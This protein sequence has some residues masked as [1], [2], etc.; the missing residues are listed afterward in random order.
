MSQHHIPTSANNIPLYKWFN[1]NA[2]DAWQ[3]TPHAGWISAMFKSQIT[4]VTSVCLSSSKIVNRGT[5]ESH[6]WSS[7]PLFKYCIYVWWCFHSPLFIVIYSGFPTYVLMFFSICW[8]YPVLTPLPLSPWLAVSTS[9]AQVKP[10]Q[11]LE[12]FELWTLYSM[13]WFY[14]NIQTGNHGFFP[15]HFWGFQVSIVYSYGPL[16]A[17]STL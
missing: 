2:V 12:L 8:V 16:P 7:F 17:I 10:S 9:V 5:A 14:G 1:L 3:S 15:W 11:R 13:D 6:G 4:V